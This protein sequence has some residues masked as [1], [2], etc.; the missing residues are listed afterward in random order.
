MEAWSEAFRLLWWLVIATDPL[1]QFYLE[2]IY[3]S[4]LLCHSVIVSLCHM[5]VCLPL[6]SFLSPFYSLSLCSL[7]I[8]Y[9][10]STLFHV[11]SLSTSRNHWFLSDTQIVH[12]KDALHFF[13]P[14]FLNKIK[15]SSKTTQNLTAVGENSEILHRSFQSFVFNFQLG[16]SSLYNVKIR[17]RFS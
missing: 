9:S 1:G 8:S 6:I 12:L 14:F 11:R 5:L 2:S 10:L 13:T 17:H 15:M 16:F 3:L 7:S 4:L